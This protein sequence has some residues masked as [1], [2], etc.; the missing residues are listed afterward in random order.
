MKN[1]IKRKRNLVFW[2]LLFFEVLLYILISICLY[3]F[4][5]IDPE[6]LDLSEFIIIPIGLGII[7]GAMDALTLDL[8][9]KTN[10]KSVSEEILYKLFEEQTDYFH[11]LD[12]S[13]HFT[14]D[15]EPYGVDGSNQCR[16]LPDCIREEDRNYF[17]EEDCYWLIFGIHEDDLGWVEDEYRDNACLPDENN[18]VDG[19]YLKLTKEQYFYLKNLKGG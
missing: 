16:D 2:I 7:F 11:L 14:Y 17:K 12:Y 8:I 6:N 18:A 13:G 15:P 3:H 4:N 10:E 9:M 19:N 1:N 5:I